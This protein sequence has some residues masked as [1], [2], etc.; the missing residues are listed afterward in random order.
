MPNK[1]TQIQ[2][3]PYVP[4]YSPPNMG[5]IQQAGQNLWKRQEQGMEAYDQ[6]QETI[7]S[8]DVLEED[9]PLLEKTSARLNE[10]LG[11]FTETNDF[12][13]AMPAI[14]RE[15]RNLKENIATGDLGVATQNRQSALDTFEKIE[16]SDWSQQE[17]EAMKNMYLKDYT[18]AEES[19]RLDTFAPP[20]YVDVERE[21][22][23]RVKELEKVKTDS[24]ELI[25]GEDGRFYKGKVTRE[26]RQKGDIDATML[27]LA[28]D[29]QVGAVLKQQARLRGEDPEEYSANKLLSLATEMNKRWGDEDAGISNIQWDD[30]VGDP[31]SVTP[32]NKV[33]V[34]SGSLSTKNI[35]PPE[36]F[37]NYMSKAW[38]HKVLGEEEEFETMK[39]GMAS[40]ASSMIKAGE[41][42]SDE[43]DYFVDN[44]GKKTAT[45]DAYK[46]Y[47]GRGMFGLEGADSPEPDSRMAEIGGKIRE[48][49]DA[50]EGVVSTNFPIRDGKQQDKA[51][52]IISQIPSSAMNLVSHL[53]EDMKDKQKQQFI[54]NTLENGTFQGV[55]VFADSQKPAWRFRVPMENED[56]EEVYETVLLEENIQ[57]NIKGDEFVTN[58]DALVRDAYNGNPAAQRFSDI[59]KLHAVPTTGDNVSQYLPSEY[60]THEH[61]GIH[62]IEDGVTLDLGKEDDYEVAKE[63]DLFSTSLR[64]LLGET[65]ETLTKQEIEDEATQVQEMV[66][67]LDNLNET[68]KSLIMQNLGDYRNALSSELRMKVKEGMSKP[69]RFTD[70]IEAFNFAKRQTE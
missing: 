10:Q 63:Y 31:Q 40:V 22:T 11:Q 30:A 48:Y 58:L 44:F 55:D 59:Q 49:V 65:G 66:Y 28:K 23:K 42:N 16:S 15:A 51:D 54:G 45:R 6:L 37:D 17:K 25:E 35:L 39:Q 56:G 38:D 3:T 68:E 27:S 26:R 14:R 13:E 60:R 21:A 12:I 50:N 64:R 2:S 69:F 7:G 18:G 20:E 67:S 47:F 24:I 32:F 19:G 33:D 46:E 36:G 52:D 29:P 70:K 57:P 62:Q 4:Q 61:I 5:V 8:L 53:G 9:K 43:F 1:F 34:S 41:L